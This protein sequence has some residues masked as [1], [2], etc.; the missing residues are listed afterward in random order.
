MFLEFLGGGENDSTDS[1]NICV[2]WT[3]GNRC[4]MAVLSY[5]IFFDSFA[6]HNYTWSIV[7]DSS[8]SCCGPVIIQ[9]VSSLTQIVLVSG[10]GFDFDSPHFV[11]N[12]DRRCWLPDFDRGCKYV[13]LLHGM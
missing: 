8:I 9:F 12:S 1:R 5:I 10:V 11:A 3:T 6:K 4:L 13:V 7:R 2:S